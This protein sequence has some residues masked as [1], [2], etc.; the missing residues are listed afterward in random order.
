MKHV[1]ANRYLWDIPKNRQTNQ[2]VTWAAFQEDNTQRQG[3]NIQ[4][5]DR[6]DVASEG[7]QLVA[8]M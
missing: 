7:A 8:S 2:H 1:L 6:A 5:V 3:R 4:I